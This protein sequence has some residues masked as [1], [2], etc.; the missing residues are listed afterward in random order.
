MSK[1]LQVFRSK[2]RLP[3]DERYACTGCGQVIDLPHT[4]SPPNH[5]CTCPVCHNKFT[6]D[7]YRKNYEATFG[8][9]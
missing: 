1:W 2:R 4:Q 3:Q 9:E 8:H 5:L 6:S 7:E